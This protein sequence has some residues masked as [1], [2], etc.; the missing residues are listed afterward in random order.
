MRAVNLI[1]HDQRRGAGGVAG[2]SGGIVYVVAGGLLVIVGLGV[3]YAFAVHSVANR[4]GQLAQVTQQVGSVQLQTAALQ[5]YVQVYTLRQAKVQAAVQL[6]QG[7]FDWPDAMRQ[8]ALALPSDV[9]LTSVTANAASPGSSATAAAPSTTT[10]VAG[11]TFVLAGCASS[12]SE[13]ALVLT[14]LQQTPGVT[15]VQLQSTAKQSAAPNS[16]P[17]GPLSK[18]EAAGGKCPL[19]GFNAT[20]TYSPTYTVPSEKLPKNGSNGAQT[21][22]THATGSHTAAAPPATVNR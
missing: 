6:A 5:P 14:R 21:V 18:A 8:L 1:P 22:S 19:V 11:P 10:T 3:I 2:R 7:R 16:A 4:K 13:T 20:L 9:T 12:Q 17:P 15:D